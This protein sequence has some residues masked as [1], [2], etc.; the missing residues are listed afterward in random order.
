MLERIN[1]DDKEIYSSKEYD[2]LALHY[3]MQNDGCVMNATLES[4]STVTFL[5][6]VNYVSKYAGLNINIETTSL[7]EGSVVRCFRFVIEEKDDN[8]WLLYIFMT[9]F[10]SIFFQKSVGIDLLVDSFDNEE[11]EQLQAILKRKQLTKEKI[12][13]LATDYVVTKHRSDFFKRISK[14]QDIQGLSIETGEKFTFEDKVKTQRII[15]DEFKDY[16]VNLLPE[17]VTIE[18]ACVYIISPVILKG[19]KAKW[20]GVFTNQVITFELKSNEFKTK[21]QNGLEFRSG[22][23][24]ICTLKYKKTI[25]GDGKEHITDY[26]VVFVLKYGVDDNYEETLEGKKKR[27][28]DNN[29]TLFDGLED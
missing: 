14:N 28:E 10:K 23:N 2:S 6:A 1:M 12:E 20:K 4:E 19:Q 29:P 26:Q 3:N 16:I 24:I 15:A 5:Q 18:N 17:E 8:H 9:L 13:K 22:S 7:K 11:R 25:D 27:I 21:A